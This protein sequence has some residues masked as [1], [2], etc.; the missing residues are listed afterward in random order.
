MIDNEWTAADEH[1]E[2]DREHDNACEL[3]STRADDCDEKVGHQDADGD[4]DRKFNRT[5]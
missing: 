1:C 5:L 4:T 3:D 2:R